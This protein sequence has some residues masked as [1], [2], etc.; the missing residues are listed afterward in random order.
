[1]YEDLV[2]SLNKFVILSDA[3]IAALNNRIELVVL[4][5]NS[6]FIEEGEIAQHI[7]WVRKGYL[8]I[9]FNKDGTD[10]TRD[11]S[12]VGS[13]FTALTSFISKQPSFEI[14]SSITDCELLLIKREDLNYLYQHY[15]NWQ[16]IGRRVVEEMFV[17]SQKRIYSLLTV[18]A[19]ERYM[20]LLRKKPELIQHVP[21]QYIASYLGITSQSLSRLRRKIVSH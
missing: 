5:K 19:E 13:F 17:R 16:T 18:S 9:S 2:F 8:R 20:E 12:S 10:I 4:E 3:E 15:P 6:V 7:A 11:I 21:L 1:M 14:V